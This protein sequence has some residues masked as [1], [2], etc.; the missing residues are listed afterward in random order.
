MVKLAGSKGLLAPMVSIGLKAIFGFLAIAMIWVAGNTVC[1]R[2]FDSMDGTIVSR[3]N[4]HET[5]IPWSYTRYRLRDANSAIVE[6]SYV[7]TGFDGSLPND[8]PVGSHIYKKDGGLDYVVDG[9][10]HP[11]P[12]LVYVTM[13]CL[14]LVFAFLALRRRSPEGAPLESGR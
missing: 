10:L 4:I 3:E 2:M 13:C 6:Y 11:F 5:G 12:F 1:E 9:Q 8:L 14:A 7:D